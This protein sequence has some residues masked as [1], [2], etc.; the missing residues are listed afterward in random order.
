MSRGN[1]VDTV[2]SAHVTYVYSVDHGS[3]YCCST[4]QA[5]DCG[6]IGARFTCSSHAAAPDGGEDPRLI[7]LE[8]RLTWGEEAC[9]NA[10]SVISVV[11]CALDGAAAVSAATLE[12]LGVCA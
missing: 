6:T 11:G 3:Q 5:R 12:I 1:T 4:I 7:R 8:G 9:R 2:R 10:S